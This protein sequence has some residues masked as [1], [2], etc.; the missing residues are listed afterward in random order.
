MKSLIIILFFGFFT[1]SF[2]QQKSAWN[3]WIVPNSYSLNEGDTL[4]IAFGI[5]G[6]GSLKP[7]N[8]KIVAYTEENT[9]IKYGDSPA[10]YDTYVIAPNENSPSDRFTRKIE[11]YP[12][13]IILNSDYHSGFGSLLL[14][15]K[16]SGDKKLILIATYS[17]DGSSW[18]TT[19]REFQYHVNS[20]YEKYQ[21]ELA[22]LGI[23]LAFLAIGPGPIAISIYNF[24]KKKI[25]KKGKVA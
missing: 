16:T 18:F 24:I 20:F 9:L 13:N 10:K 1:M 12:N 23:I 25:N 22:I 2:C 14:T 5:T 15:P 8:L 6:Y 4:K 17:P 3:I 11:G 7:S 21:T 19:S